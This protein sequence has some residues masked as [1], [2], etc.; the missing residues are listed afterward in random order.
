MNIVSMPNTYLLLLSYCC[1]IYGL[2]SS[3]CKDA[4][5]VQ[6]KAIYF[7][8]L[9]QAMQCV[10]QHIICTSSWIS[11]SVGALYPIDAIQNIVEHVF[12]NS[13]SA[14]RNSTSVI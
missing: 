4:L 9:W 7:I 5:D 6:S 12:T 1:I 8:Q 13:R 10:M 14:D 3:Y 11:I 2:S